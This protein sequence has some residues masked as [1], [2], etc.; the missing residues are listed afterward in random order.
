[1]ITLANCP[2]S[3]RGDLTR[4][5]FEID[6]GVYVGQVSSRVR[7]ELWKRIVENV[8]NGRALMVYSSNSEQHLDFK[9]HNTLWEPIDFDGLKLIMRPS[10]SRLSSIGQLKSGYSK[11]AGMR[12]VKQINKAKNHRKELL[13]NY[14]VID[15][16]TTGLSVNNDEIIEIGALIVKNNIVAEKFQSLVKNTKPIPKSIE[17]LT[18]ITNQLIEEEGRELDEVLSS[19]L[20]FVGDYK[21]ISHNPEFDYSFLR[22]ACKMHGLPLFS[23]EYIDTLKLSKKNLTDI[24]NYKLVTLLNHFDIQ[25]EKLHRSLSDCLATKELFDKLNEMG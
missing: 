21:V 2:Q 16:E 17:E 19:F 14:V 13:E 23:N 3:L 24:D 5:L 6:T 25:Y 1:V 4:W 12:K 7:E 8:K 18:G 20:D 10:P 9:V 11:A 15:I 22:K